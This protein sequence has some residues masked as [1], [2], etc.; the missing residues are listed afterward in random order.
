LIG[1]AS[2][3]AMG[4]LADIDTQYFH[5]LPKIAIGHRYAYVIAIDIDTPRWCHAIDTHTIAI[6]Q[7]YTQ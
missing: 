5:T 3:T 4:W 1:F 2:H 6:L 7:Y